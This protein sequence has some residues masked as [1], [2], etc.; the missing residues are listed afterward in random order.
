MFHRQLHLS[1]QP[2]TGAGGILH[3]TMLQ[4]RGFLRPDPVKP[5]RSLQIFL[6]VLGSELVQGGQVG[7]ARS[8]EAEC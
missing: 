1:G 4:W 2:E 6:A 7:L 5:S 8:A 3:R